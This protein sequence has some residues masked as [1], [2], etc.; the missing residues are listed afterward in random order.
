MVHVDMAGRRRA[1]SGSYNPLAD[2][3]VESIGLDT[4]TC[5]AESPV[6][7]FQKPSLLSQE[8]GQ[9]KV[10]AQITADKEGDWLK[11]KDT[12]FY[13]PYMDKSGNRLFKNDRLG[14]MQ[15][16]VSGEGD[17][18][19]RTSSRNSLSS[20][21]SGAS[22]KRSNSSQEGAIVRRQSFRWVDSDGVSRRIA[23][24][25]EV[26][27]GVNTRPEVWVC[28][29]EDGVAYRSS[30]TLE[31]LCGKHCGA[32]SKVTAVK[33][34]DWLKVMEVKESFDALNA[35]EMLGRRSLKST[36]RVT[37][38][39]TGLYLPFFQDGQRLFKNEKVMVIEAAQG[40]ENTGNQGDKG[41][42]NVM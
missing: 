36:T 14:L 37:V 29:A 12:G 15:R 18:P 16:A 31:D 21:S 23:G 41:S 7:L 20:K 3:A 5:V 13:A 22:S 32:G 10:G 19:M 27:K 1:S 11:V 30:P 33:E 26:L 17:D 9:C 2:T 38:V 4:W 35:A 24:D 42:C 28:V 6:Q 8:E 39:D 25:S 34:D 40:N